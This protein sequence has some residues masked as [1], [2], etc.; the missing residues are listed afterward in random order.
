MSGARTPRP[1]AQ[2]RTAAEIRSDITAQQAE[3]AGSVE[4]LRGRVHE[5]TDWRRQISEHRDQLIAG[6]AIT[7]FVV[8]GLIALRRRRR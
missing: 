7:G 2:G 1:G 6:A 3:L 4:I 8:G 5:L